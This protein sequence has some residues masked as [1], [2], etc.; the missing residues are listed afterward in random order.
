MWIRFDEQGGISGASRNKPPWAEDLDE[1]G[2]KKYNY[3]R[4]DRKVVYGKDGG[5]F[6]EDEIPE[7]QKPPTEE[8]KAR[9]TRQAEIVAGLDEIDRQSRRPER[10]LKVAELMAKTGPQ[11]D[12]DRLMALE[13]RA[14]ELRA[15]LAAIEVSR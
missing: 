12:K 10:A 15:E 7:D 14:E 5:M 11:E 1:A 6:F 3:R 8:E 9:K 2:H 4:T 13:A